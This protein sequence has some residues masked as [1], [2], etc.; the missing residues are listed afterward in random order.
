MRH[1]LNEALPRNQGENRDLMER[2]AISSRSTPDRAIGATC[3]PSFDSLARFGLVKKTTRKEG[4]KGRI[5]RL[6][7]T[8]VGESQLMKWQ[9]GNDLWGQAMALFALLMAACL[10]LGGCDDV[11][12][13]K[14]AHPESV[15]KP[16]VSLTADDSASTPP[17]LELFEVAGDCR[18]GDKDRHALQNA[19]RSMM[20]E[21][22]QE[23]RRQAVQ[24]RTELDR[25]RQADAVRQAEMRHRV[26][27]ALHFNRQ[28]LGD[29]LLWDI[30]SRCDP[31]MV[32]D[33]GNK[34][35]VTMAD[36][37]AF[38]RSN[39]FVAG[40]AGVPPPDF[41]EEPDDREKLNAAYAADKAFRTALVQAGVRYAVVKTAWPRLP[42]DRRNR[43]TE[44]I[45]AQV[46]TTKAVPDAAREVENAFLQA[47]RNRLQR[48]RDNAALADLRR[49]FEGMNNVTIAQRKLDGVNSVLAT[50]NTYFPR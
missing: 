13:A 8:A 6:S 7:W 45:K 24:L 11:G 42:A 44:I 5:A 47:E 28:E 4:Q 16:Q 12:P 33:T 14:A 34:D 23:M 43:V 41:S 49:F 10:A 25:Y 9:A 32:E 29:P 30:L 15:W 17:I 22:P 19:L 40:L 3:P 50:E 46:R 1:Y 31:V 2:Q 39:R 26:R 48:Q 18:L 38:D 21:D 36:L 37:R 20:L 27:A 35:I